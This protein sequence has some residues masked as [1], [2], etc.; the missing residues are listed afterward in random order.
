M[1]KFIRDFGKQFSKKARQPL[2]RRRNA[3]LRLEELE[4]RQLMSAT[5]LQVAAELTHSREYYGNV[6]QKAYADFLGRPPEPPGLKDWIG[7]LQNGLTD[8]RLEAGFIGSPEYIANHGGTGPA[9]IEGMYKDLLGRGPEVG[10]LE[11]WIKRL[12]SGST[13]E[14]IAFGF[15]A[16]AE[17][18]GLHVTGNYQRYLGRTPDADGLKYWVNQFINH[19]QTNEDLAAGF[20]G[21][22]EYITNVN[23]DITV[24]L[25]TAF[26]HVLNRLPDAT[27]V[28]HWMSQL[29]VEA[30]S[31]DPAP[32]VDDTTIPVSDDLRI[33]AP[34]V[35]A[36]LT[37]L[38]QNTW[39][40]SILGTDYSDQISV[41]ETG[42]MVQV[43][44]NGRSVGAFP[45]STIRSIEIRGGAGND[46]IDGFAA[47]K[48]MVIFG[49]GGNDTIRGGSADD[50]LDGGSGDDVLH[51]GKS[52]N[53]YHDEF[54]PSRWAVNGM[55]RDDVQ[56]G[57]GGTC[58][59]LA[60]LAAAVDYGN[61][62]ENIAYLGNIPTAYD[63]SRAGFWGLA[64]T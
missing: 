27:E 22:Q 30:P 49:E 14:S 19:G 61:L 32:P 11:F 40:L 28:A 58:T 25:N 4:G 35:V 20:V 59:I 1:L 15:A 56:Q 43:T 36:N 12:N 46:W 10:G 18:E 64:A 6:A 7:K 51:R 21:S 55:T 57:T 41:Q 23:S 3:V 29:G 45:A 31:I 54:D 53:T 26:T 16:S 5:P 42:G 33:L 63:C 47:T 39:K 2:L 34:T 38:I 24:W 9:W 17:R 50:Y 44:A 48:P 52:H 37:D 62:N 13:P 60:T 8:E